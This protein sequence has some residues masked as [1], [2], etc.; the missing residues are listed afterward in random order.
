MSRGELI[1]HWDDDDWMAPHRISL[2]VARLLETDADLCGTRDLLH[3]RPDAGEA[4]L[5]RYPE[6]ERSW[7]AGGTLLYRR[8][9]W[10]R[11]H[12]PE[13]DL[14]EDTAFIW[15]LSLTVQSLP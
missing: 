4:W 5:Y 1:A 13:I 10:F 2:Q 12:F 11:H 7:L 9:A 15:Q 14:G 6:H 8:S 3:Y